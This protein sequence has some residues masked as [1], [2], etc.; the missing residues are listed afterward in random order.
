MM[1][2]QLQ[3][4]FI[5]VLALIALCLTTIAIAE[6]GDSKV[7]SITLPTVEVKMKD[8]AGKDKVEQYCNMCHSLDYI[9]SQPK[10]T[11]K[12]WG[13]TVHKMVEKYGAPVPEADAKEITQYLIDQY[14]VSEAKK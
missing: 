5:A 2:K 13:D 11:A 9:T 6:T 8:G 3:Q 7:H 10:L 14:G 1:K 12:Q 4:V